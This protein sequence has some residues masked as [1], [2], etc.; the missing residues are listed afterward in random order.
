MSRWTATRALT[1][2]ALA[3]A[4]AWLLLL[5][6]W[7]NAPF[8]LTFDDAYYYFGIARNV[9][10][11]HGSTFDGINQT[12]GYHPLWLALSVPFFAIGLDDLVAVRVLLAFQVLLWGTALVV[13]ARSAGRVMDGWVRLHSKLGSGID[14]DGTS[15][16]ATSERWCIGTVVVGFVLL[17]GNPFIVKIFVNG[18]E[19]GVTV[20]LFALLLAVAAP[21]PTRRGDAPGLPG[22]GPS[23]LAGRSHANRLAIGGLLALLFLGRTDSVIVMGCLGLWIL[24]T[25]WP[26]DKDKVIGIFEVFGPAAVTA[27]IYLAWNQATF[28]T[29]V[30]ISGTI[31]RV[32]VTPTVA[33]TFSVFVAIAAGLM[34]GALGRSRKACRVNIPVGRFPRV[35]SFARATAW[36]AAAS[37]I[38]IGYYNV[39]QSQQWLWYYCPVGIY[40]IWLAVLGIADFAES[41]LVEAPATTSTARALL[42]VQALLLVPLVAL[43]VWQ[44]LQ[45][46]DPE[47][48]SIQEANRDAGVWIDDN[49]PDDA[50]LASWD[51]GVVGYFSHRSVINLDGVVNSK[52][53][54]DAGRNGTTGQFLA[55]R[56]LGWIVNHG[57]PEDGQDQA[58]IA[59][60][61]STFGPDAAAGT[62]LEHTVPFRYSGTTTGSGGT[63]SGTRDLAVFLYRLPQPLTV[64]N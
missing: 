58:I 19:S 56:N 28:G 20:L 48:R 32:D 9:A 47:L 16:L 64:S 15:R 14:A 3:V 13:I 6:V 57:L 49:L 22:E 21:R 37:V 27:A 2:A 40:L 34:I 17:A 29:P 55:D 60:V 23:W 12:N 63:E 51:A 10:D 5:A 44:S 31:K 18:L 52:E 24:A 43:L 30:Q 62:E 45:F 36:Y 46:F 25:S 39:L 61:D 59:F 26:L 1:V 54:Y 50:V 8:T 11:G 41:A 35:T 7:P 42:P 4:A 53:W 33:I 38:L